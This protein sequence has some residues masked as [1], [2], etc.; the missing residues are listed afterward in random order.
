MGITRKP[1]F[2]PGHTT[3]QALV[4]VICLSVLSFLKHKMER[5]PSVLQA[6]CRDLYKKTLCKLKNNKIYTI[7]NI[8]IAKLKQ[9]SVIWGD[10][11]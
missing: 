9:I 3:E 1:S 6:F 2:K 5:I 7:I 11:L 10:D 4:Q 8:A